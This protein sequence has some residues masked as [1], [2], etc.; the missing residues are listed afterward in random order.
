MS[1]TADHI[2]SLM[3]MDFHFSYSSPMQYT[4]NIFMDYAPFIILF[5]Q[6]LNEH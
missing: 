6:N 2:P 1:S 3:T 4:T 5:S